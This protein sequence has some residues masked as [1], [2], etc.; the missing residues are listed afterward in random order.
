MAERNISGYYVSYVQN[1]GLSD[2]LVLKYDVYDGNTDIKGDEITSS[3]NSKV[4]AADLKYTTFGFGLAHFFDS[5]VK[6]TLYYD[7]VKNE[8]LSANAPASLAA[9]KDDLKDNV[10]TLRMQYKF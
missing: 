4:S 5:N 9:Y 3:V 8:K 7:I 2:Q 6:F 10:L 1:L